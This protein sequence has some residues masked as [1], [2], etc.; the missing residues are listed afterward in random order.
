M[1]LTHLHLDETIEEKSEASDSVMNITRRI[2]RRFPDFKVVIFHSDLER[3]L[4]TKRIEFVK[5]IKKKGITLD[6]SPPRI[7]QPNDGS[8]RSG[9]LIMAVNRCLRISANHPKH[10]WPESSHCADDIANLTPVKSLGRKT[11]LGEHLGLKLP[12]AAF[13]FSYGSKAYYVRDVNIAK[14]DKMNRTY[15]GCLV[16]YDASNIFRIW[17]EFM[18]YLG[19]RDLT[20]ILDLSKWLN[21]AI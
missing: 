3:T 5:F 2:D 19:L 16:A 6:T 12:P 7:P 1:I 20:A 21:A 15:I 4:D 13:L 8:E 14:G 10:I 9:Q 11:P 17:E 18:R